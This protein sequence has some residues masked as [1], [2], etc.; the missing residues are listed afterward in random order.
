MSNSISSFVNGAIAGAGA[1][2][3]IMSSALLAL[4]APLEVS[5]ALTTT[6]LRVAIFLGA[7]VFAVATAYEFYKNKPAKLPQDKVPE[8]KESS[9]KSQS[10]ESAQSQ[11]ENKVNE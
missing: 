2:L 7:I 9:V 4:Y 3:A 8:D 11:Q 10:P 5:K 1:V 6:E